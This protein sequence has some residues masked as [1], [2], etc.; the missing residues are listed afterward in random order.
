MIGSVYLFC[1]ALGSSF[2]ILGALVG[3]FM[4]ADHGAGDG[5][6]HIGGD[7]GG[8]FGGDAG[9]G[10]EAGSDSATGD[11]G[12]GDADSGGGHAAS[13]HLPILSPTVISAFVAFFGGS[14]LIYQNLLGLAHPWLH[15]PLALGT[16]MLV[17]LGMAFGMWKL[18]SMMSSNRVA[19]ISDA[20]GQPVEVSVTVPVEGAGEIS[21]ISGGTR[22]ALVARA[23]DG[24]EHKQGSSARVLRVAEGM[25]WIAETNR[26][27]S[28]GISTVVEEVGRGEPVVPGDRPRKRH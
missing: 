16:A 19:R 7:A 5:G 23:L 6:G 13:I 15:I 26:L 14:G 12:H 11:M 3:H 8:H 1:L 4:S 9:H 28:E 18:T 25:A 27:T 21:Y 2:T 10:Y 24:R 20:F 17:G 22:Q